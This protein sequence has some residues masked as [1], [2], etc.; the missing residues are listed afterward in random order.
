VRALLA[1]IGDRANP[2]W[3]ASAVGVY[4]FGATYMG[5]AVGAVHPAFSD[6]LGVAAAITAVGSLTFASGVVVAIRMV[7]GR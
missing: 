5:Y 7:G 4:R 3:R 6:W 1:A 2:R